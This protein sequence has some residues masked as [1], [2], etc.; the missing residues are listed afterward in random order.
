MQA[1]SGHPAG[2]VPSMEMKSSGRFNREPAPAPKEISELGI[3]VYGTKASVSRA[4]A[5]SLPPQ[6]ESRPKLLKHATNGT[7]V[8]HKGKLCDSHGH[9][10]DKHG[11]KIPQQPSASSRHKASSSSKDPQLKSRH[12]PII[13]VPEGLSALINMSNA[14]Q[15]L[16]VRRTCQL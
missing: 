8:N 15:F 7:F 2:K 11:K 5:A 12:I 10:L 16:E 3:D 13:I 6:P 4:P 1:P 9:L 14:R